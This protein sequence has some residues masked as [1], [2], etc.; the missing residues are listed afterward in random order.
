VTPALVMDFALPF[1]LDLDLTLGILRRGPRDRTIRF[2]GRTVW[3]ATRTPDGAATLRLEQQAG[4][5]SAAAWGPGAAWALRAV[6]TLIGL[7][8]DPA[9]FRPQHPLLDA[10]HR[11]H[12]GLRLGRT[13]AVF[14]TLLPT[15]LEQKVPS[16]EAWAAYA[17]LVETLGEPAPGD[18]GLMVPPSP[19][20]LTATPYWALHR[21]GIERRKAEIIRNAASVARHLD[22]MV[23]LAL[24]EA[25]WR[26]LGLP[27][28]GPWSASEIAIVA[29]GDRDSVSLGD[30]NLPN[31][32]S[33]ALA[34]EPRGTD[35]RMLGLLEPYRG[36]RARVLR[37][38]A[39]AGITAPRFGPRMPLRRFARS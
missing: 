22:A 36:H 1:P 30:Y 2:E 27:G 38:L 3:R 9:A 19:T 25:R 24:P 14:E 37:L 5:L 17:R 32:V 33:W 8:D 10:I 11:R 26:L 4:G 6:P 31:T 20:R 7:D 18:A 13:G 28:I 34:G 39:V 16:V 29:L 15:V 23:G 21:F 12:G 35:E